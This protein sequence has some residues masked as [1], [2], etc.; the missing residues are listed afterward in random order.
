MRH[1]ASL[2]CITNPNLGFLPQLIYEIWL[3]HESITDK[4]SDEQTDGRAHERLL[5]GIFYVRANKAKSTQQVLFKLT[6]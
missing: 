6:D 4:H 5:F 3:G 2:R 1:S